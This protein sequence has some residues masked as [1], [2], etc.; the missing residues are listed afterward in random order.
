MKPHLALLSAAL[1]LTACAT[2]PGGGDIAAPDHFEPG[3]CAAEA[4]QV[5]IGQRTVEIHEPSLP[6][7]Y[8]I[9]A[10][11][12]AVTMDHR[13]DRLNIVT[14]NGVVAEVTCG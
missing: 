13:P 4:Y 3:A 8:R 7:P 11:G 10:R 2:P 1:L 9:Y 12:D 5:L 14:E 6:R